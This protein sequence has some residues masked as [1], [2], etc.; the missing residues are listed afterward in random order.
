VVLNPTSA[1]ELLKHARTETS[2]V[3]GLVDGKTVEEKLRTELLAA[4]KTGTVTVST[5]DGVRLPFVSGTVNVI[6]TGKKPTDD[7]RRALAPYGSAIDRKGRVLWKKAYPK[8]MDEWT[9]Y[10]YAPNGNA[11][12]K[13]KLIGPPRHIKWLA[14]PK[15]LRHHDHL[16]SLSAMVS[17]GGRVFYVYDETTSASI[18][19]PPDWQLI[20]RDA[21]NGVVLW[22]KGIEEWHPHLWPLKSMPAALPRRLVAVGDDVYVT[23]GI[24]AP[25]SQL[26]ATDGRQEKTFKGSEGCEEIIVTGNTLLALCLV[27]QGPLDDLDLERGAGSDG[28]DGRVTKFDHARSLMGGIKSPLW[29]N[30]ERRIVAFDLES[31][32]QRWQADT[33][34][35]PLSM[36]TDGHR[37]YFHDSD[38]VVALDFAT[39][40][41]LWTSEPIPVWEE[42]YS[43]FGASLVVHDDIVIFSG[44]ENFIW[45]SGGTRGAD[46]TMTAVSAIDGKKLWS[47]P[48][49]PSGYR[50][51]EDLLVAQGLVWAPNVTK[52]SSSIMNGLD[53]RSGEI[54]RSVEMDLQHGFHH[55]CYS[56]RATETYLLASKVGINSVAFDGSEV[57]NDHWLRGACG[58]GIMPANGLIYSTP[59]P[60]N[61]FPDSK[62]NGFVGLAAEDTGLVAYRDR[63]ARKTAVERGPAYG[64]KVSAL[65]AQE[66]GAWPTY[67]G[68]AARRASTSNALPKGLGQVWRLDVGGRLSAPVV[69]DG[70]VFISAIDDNQL[71]A[72]DVA[73]GKI[74]WKHAAGGRVDSPPT[75]VGALLY[76]GAADG[77]V[78]CLTAADG[79]MVWRRRIAPTDEKLVNDGRLES[80]WPVHGAVTYHNDRIYAV[81]GRNMFVDGGLFMAAL[82]PLTGEVRHQV[83]HRPAFTS[84]GMNTVPARTDIISTAGDDLF[85]C[86]QLYDAEC[87]LVN[88]T[89]PHIYAVNG[90]LNDSWFHRA[91]WTY[92]AAFKGGC[93]GFGSTGNASHSGRIMA[94]DDS[95]L[96][97][98]GRN[99]YGWGSAFTYQLYKAP[100]GMIA[101][102]EP[103]P[104]PVPAK[105]SRKGKK[106]KK[107]AK[108]PKKTPRE[109]SVDIP[110]LA[111][112]IIKADDKLL[113]TGPAKLYDE[114]EMIQRLPSPEAMETIA[115]QT[116]KWGS[117]GEMVVVS[118]TDGSVLKQIR[119]GFAPMWD[120]VAVAEDSIFISGN[121]GALYR[122]K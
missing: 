51:P 104:E 9:H 98:F 66:G 61:C 119:L 26:D 35:A 45:I 113:I 71:I 8:A 17:G 33:K 97:G 10:L 86:S 25:V 29:L 103:T 82:D 18:L 13:D 32:K 14:G 106:G 102:K 114:N 107:K 92:S 1:G 34:C 23:L 62:L 118:A 91:F 48:H 78:T 40:K 79:A 111:R 110:V 36:A 94:S 50:S 115:R 122:L 30:A 28:L 93:G 52:K 112:S 12:A 69:A 70:R 87:R 105:K 38:S 76:F 60:C 15:S 16:P 42:F 83:N 41:T 21:F 95:D 3:H 73:S 6:V 47:A 37:V 88:E 65:R 101:P 75:I 120:G 117:E 89:V 99:R 31:G 7:M 57:T 72:V 109:W 68:S 27:G 20:A 74:A 55:R 80:V 84:G 85:M 19:F 44:G 24:N 81:A 96:Y 121:D 46:D 77:T 11:V 116:A 53:P 108:G 4:G 43:P 90:Y 67:R 100:L 63:A 49:P 58:Y 56:S 39:G 54:V 59:D 64:V 2:L 5:W 22:K